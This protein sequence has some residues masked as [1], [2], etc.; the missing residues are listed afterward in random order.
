MIRFAL[1]IL[2]ASIAVGPILLKRNFR[3]RTRVDAKE[4]LLA[5]LPENVRAFMTA[6]LAELA[7][8]GF[9][10]YDCFDVTGRQAGVTSFITV[11]VNRASRERANLYFACASGVE[12]GFVEFLACTSNGRSVETN[13]NGAPTPMFPRPYFVYRFPQVDDASLLYR[14]HRHFV[15]QNLGDAALVFPAEGE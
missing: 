5:D 10:A 14:L 6:T 7:S 9:G 15:R 1:L 12:R 3:F 2:A 4:V 13:T 8:L 11:A